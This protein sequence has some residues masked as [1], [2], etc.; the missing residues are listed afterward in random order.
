MSKEE[1]QSAPSVGSPSNVIEMRPQIDWKARVKINQ[2]S[3]EEA[4]A[5]QEKLAGDR[6]LAFELWMTA[7][8][9]KITRLHRIITEEPYNVEVSVDQLRRWHR[10][11]VW[12]VKADDLQARMTP[13]LKGRFQGMAEAASVE[14]M[15]RLLSAAHGEAMLTGPEVA[16]A[17]VAIEAAGWLPD[18]RKTA[19]VT[20]HYDGEQ[21]S[22]VRL[23]DDQREALSAGLA[24]L[25]DDAD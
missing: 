17:K 9:R 21:R 3:R 4:Q 14:W 6:E 24:E 19:S 20:M 10:N 5:R 12:D 18:R 1:D 7:A 13:A 15:G 22:S 11:D 25:L 16:A 23:S 8:G 2:R